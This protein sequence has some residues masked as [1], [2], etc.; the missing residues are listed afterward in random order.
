MRSPFLYCVVNVYAYK[1]DKWSVKHA[2]VHSIV[3]K[4][5]DPNQIYVFSHVL[6]SSKCRD[7]QRTCATWTSCPAVWKEPNRMPDVA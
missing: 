6:L 5:I 7:N 1:L 2:L 3:V 4:I